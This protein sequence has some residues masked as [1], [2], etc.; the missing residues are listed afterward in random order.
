M[1]QDPDRTRDTLAGTFDALAYHARRQQHLYSV[2]IAALIAVVLCAGTLLAGLATDQHLDHRRSQ[3]AQYVGTVSQRL[4]NEASFV[5]RT[6]LSIRYH[7]RAAVAAPSRDPDVEALRRTGAAGVH[8]EAVRKDYHLLAADAT[9]RAW[10]AGL[11]TEFAR[12]RQVALA[13]VATQQAFD[14]DHGAYAVSLYEDSAV[15][16]RQPEPDARAPLALDPTLIPRLRTQ[17]T[18]ALVDRTGHAVPARD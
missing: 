3:V 14:L 1:Q 2:T 8:V 7:L 17:L 9:R 11:P 12:L 6:A 15:V 5:R 4:H 18:R 16:I 13:A 10:G